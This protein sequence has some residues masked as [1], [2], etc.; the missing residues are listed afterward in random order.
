MKDT[1]KTHHLGAA[2][3][4]PN[5]MVTQVFNPDEVADILKVPKRNIM[6]LLR[7]GKLLGVKVGRHWRITE[8][9]LDEYLNLK[10]GE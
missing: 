1:S 6:D 4:K 10:R 8:E 7:A 3:T 2:S 9:A 5:P